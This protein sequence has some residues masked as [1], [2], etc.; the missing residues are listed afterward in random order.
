M[1]RFAR[2][3][4]P[5]RSPSA[6]GGASPVHDD[7]NSGQSLRVPRTPA[8]SGIPTL[9]A[10]PAT[11]PRELQQPPDVVRPRCVSDPHLVNINNHRAWQIDAT[12]QCPT[13]GACWDFAVHLFTPDTWGAALGLSNRLRDCIDD[14]DGIWDGICPKCS[15]HSKRDPDEDDF[16]DDFEIASDGNI[17]EKQDLDD[18]D[19]F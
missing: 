17:H 8:P 15:A 2:N 5:R 18:L 10:L 6:R 12:Y 13:C 3:V 16:W 4:R 11:A 9:E 1:S 19:D 7:R 14:G